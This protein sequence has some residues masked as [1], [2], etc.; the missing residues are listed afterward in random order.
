[1]TLMQLKEFITNKTIPND[2]M[3]FSCKDNHFLAQQYLNEISGQKT[4]KINKISSIFEPQQNSLFLLT[5]QEGALNVLITEVF[6]ERAEDYSQFTD[7]IVICDKI[8]KTIENQ[9]ANYVIEMP[10]FQ[11]WQIEDYAKTICPEIEEAD[12]KWLVGAANS[13]IYR[14][15][16]ELDKI[17]IFNKEARKEVF[18]NVRYDKNSDLYT[19]DLFAIVNAIVD[20]DNRALYEFL[21][22]KDFNT[23]EPIVLSNRVLSSLKNILL[24][25]TNMTATAEELGISQAQLNFIKRKYGGRLQ[26]DLI[27]R[28]IAF[29]TNIDLKLKTSQLELSK[30]AMLSYIIANTCFRII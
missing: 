17:R 12:L 25:S 19:L 1:M 30:E 26:V 4:G 13:D 6:D 10:K 7:T 28:K 20:G 11:T 16:N 23:L 22:H 9:V 15:L 21:S 3:I 14:V 29:L 5:D 18:S 27:R 24:V 2:F 8:D